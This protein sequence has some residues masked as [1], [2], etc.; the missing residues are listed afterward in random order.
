MLPPD[1]WTSP[2][3]EVATTFVLGFTA[4]G[5]GFGLPLD[6]FVSPPTYGETGVDRVR[7]GGGPLAP[8]TG[9]ESIM[10]ATKESVIAEIKQDCRTYF[11]VAVSSLGAGFD[12]LDFVAEAVLDFAE[13]VFAMLAFSACTL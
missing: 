5:F 6:A 10:L 7:E 8:M 4:L 3:C 1:F 13:L 11:V 2:C 9:D 12:A